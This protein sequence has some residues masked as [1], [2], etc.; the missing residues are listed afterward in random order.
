[1]VHK[2]SSTLSDTDR[3]HW[4]PT[5]VAA[6]YLRGHG[7]EPGLLCDECDAARSA[8]HFEPVLGSTPWEFL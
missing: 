8:E 1:M 3:N 6:C 5:V 2:W 4:W 7:D